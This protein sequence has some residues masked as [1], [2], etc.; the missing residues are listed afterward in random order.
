MTLTFA[1]TYNMVAYLTKS[2]AN[3]EFNQIIDFLNG[4]SIKYA[5]TVNPNIYV[6]CIKQVWTTVAVKKV[7]DVTRLQT[8][9]DK[10]NMV[11]TESTIRD[12]L[13][14]DD[15]EGV[16]CLPNQEIFAELARMGYEKPSTKLIEH[17]GM[18]LARQWHLL[19]S[20]YLQVG[21]GFSRVETPLFEEIIVE[22]QVA[23]GNDD[24]HDGV[25]AAGIVTE[26]VVSA[27]NDEVPTAD[28]Q[29]SIPSPIPPTP[30]PQPSQ[31]IPSTSQ[32]QPTPPQ[33]P[34]AQQP[35]PQ[36]QP[37]PSQ[38]VGLP[39]VLLQNLLDT[40]I[41]LTGRVEHLEQDKI[42]QDLEITKLKQRV[43]KLERR[44][45]ERMITNMD[46]DTDV[47][48]EEAKD[49]VVDAK[50]NQDAEKDKGVV[51][52]DPEESTTTSTVIYSEAKSKDKAKRKKLEEEVEELKRHLQIVPN[53][54]DDVYTEA[55]PLARKVPVVDYEIYNQNNKPY[56][57]I[58]RADGSHQL[59][60][61][62]LSLLRN[63][64]R[65]D[66]EAL[67]SLVKE[68]FAITKPKNFFER[69]YPLTK[70][71]L[72]HMLN[73]VRF[74][75]DEESERIRIEQYIQMMDY[76][77]W[78]VIENGS[79]LPKTQVVK[80]VTTLMPITSV[81][82]KAQRKLEVKS[83]S[84]LM[85]GI[86]N[87]HQLKFNSIKDARQLM[88]AIEK[89]F[90]KLTV[91]GNDTIGF[92]KSNMECYNCH[93]RGHF[94]TGCKAPRSQDTKHKESIRRTLHV[95]IPASTALI[96]C[97]DEFANKP[98]VENCNAKT[99]EAK[100]KHVRKNND[101]LII[102]EC[103]LDNVEEEM[104]QPKIEQ[105]IVK[106][107]IR[108]IKFVKPKQPEKKARKNVK[109]SSQDDGFQPSSD[110]R[111][112]VD[113]DLSK[114]S[115]Y[116]DQEQDDNVNSTNIVNA[117]ST[118]EVNVVS[119]NISNELPFDPNMPVLEHICTFNFSSDD[120]DD[121]DDDDDE[122]DMNNMDTTI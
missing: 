96:S 71:T 37:Q 82:E 67:W 29:P 38:D 84:T 35:T 105:K 45:K 3:E 63:F 76:A 85:I 118:N 42:S 99:S 20:T 2:D 78:D 28:E 5:L 109:Q 115:E 94:A 73:N 69:K 54:E 88:E 61:S 11:V 13:C 7:N 51:I 39:M 1:E 23:E 106:P 75:V 58:K 104:T 112:K 9:V 101:S 25:P 77:L 16:D 86:P 119:E 111:K 50:V 102:K 15:A 55:T 107:S 8:L 59:Y 36:S 83:R 92:D 108:K 97:D 121:D 57:K 49:V 6:S 62:F 22:Q 72:N 44:N 53:D 91:N 18:S 33:S 87:E 80:G 113:E 19:S 4:S 30:P 68:R 122:A 47:V 40:C 14:L 98:V 10:K 60:L 66:L 41:T 52:R 64:D 95:E 56:Y 32:V 120:D 17:H 89:K 74:E 21:K 31:D 26:G 114:G 24:V 48:L 27:T 70:F 79:S 12:V 110:S 34:H 93:K 103:V 100:P 90:G 65:E 81:E 46:A 43:K 116:R 117:A